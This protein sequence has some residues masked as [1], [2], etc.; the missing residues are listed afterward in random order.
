MKN[1]EPELNALGQQEYILYKEAC[2]WQGISEEH[3]Q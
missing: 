2:A 1:I 3:K